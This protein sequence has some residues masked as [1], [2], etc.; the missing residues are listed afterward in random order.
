MLYINDLQFPEEAGLGICL[1]HQPEQPFKLLN[2][3]L[4]ADDLA[5]LAATAIHTQLMLIWPADCADH[6]SLTENVEK[7]RTMCFN[8]GRRPV[9]VELDY[10]GERIEQVESFSYLS[11]LFRSRLNLTQ[12]A[13]K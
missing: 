12:A 10:K 1:K 13:E 3:V 2:A 4:F 9:S 5:L 8:Q 7:C 11:M 6:K